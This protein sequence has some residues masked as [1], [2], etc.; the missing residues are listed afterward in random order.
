MAP[1]AVIVWLY[2]TPCVE[3]GSVEGFTVSVTVLTVKLYAVD[4]VAP[5]LS[6]AVIVKLNEPDEVGV[7]VIAPVDVFKDKPAGKVPAETLYVIAPVP[8]VALTL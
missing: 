7:P 6:V 2:A 3:F 8:P 1:D 5:R 4:P